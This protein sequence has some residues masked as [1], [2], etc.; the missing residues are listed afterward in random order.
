MPPVK[1]SAALKLPSMSMKPVGAAAA[2][3]VTS[4]FCRSVWP[5]KVAGVAPAKA[6]STARCFSA[7]PVALTL[8]STMSAPVADSSTRRWPSGDIVAVIP[9]RPARLLIVSRSVAK[10]AEAL[11]MSISIGV[12]FVP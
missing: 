5:E 7:A 4:P 11:A 6:L 12:A 3:S 9:V 1:G 10:C 2:R 8:P